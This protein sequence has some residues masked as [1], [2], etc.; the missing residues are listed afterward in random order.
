MGSAGAKA[1]LAV[2][3]A[4]LVLA[5]IFYANDQRG[6]GG[7]RKYPFAVGNPGPGQAAPPISLPST[8]GGTFD[9]SAYRGKTVLLYFQ[10]GIGCQPCWEQI[11]DIEATWGTFQ[12]L[13][14]DAVVSITSDP[15]S[16]LERKAADE[17]I[18]TPVLSDPDLAVSKTYEANRYGMMGTSKNGHSFVLVGKDGVIVWRA[19]YGGAPDYTMRVPAGSL[20]ADVRAGLA[21]AN[22]GR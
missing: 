7:V 13:G 11:K 12:S 15:L 8:D 10:E 1:A 5:A 6:E 4:I 20:I 3:G 19:D 17:K 21:A 16:A 22:G 18:R 14:V 9:L 2:G